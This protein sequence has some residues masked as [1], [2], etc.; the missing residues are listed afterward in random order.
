VV[1]PYALVGFALDRDGA[2]GERM[3]DDY[4]DDVDTTLS[5]AL[6]AALAELS[7][8][9]KG[10]T[11]NA[12]TYSYT[13]ADLGEVVRATRP[14]LAACGLVA[15]TPVHGLGDGLAVTVTIIHKAGGFY[16]FEPLP[17]PAGRDAQATGSAMTYFRRYALLAALGIATDDDDGAAAK[18]EPASA[19]P[20]DPL[21]AARKRLGRR[22]HNLGDGPRAVLRAWLKAEGLPDRPG[23][24]D[25]DQLQQVDAWLDAD[26]D[27]DGAPS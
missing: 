12:G 14:A 19:K 6:V 27:G 25:L 10:R 15:L 17:F 1:V 8:V 7:T 26:R 9:D 4:T 21:P 16:R 3:T 20:V 13:Y 23:L 2:V 24:M 18:A 5:G 22:V 11:A